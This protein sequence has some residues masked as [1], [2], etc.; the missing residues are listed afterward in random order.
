L[1]KH[2]KPNDYVVFSCGEIDCRWHIPNHKAEFFEDPIQA[3]KVVVYRYLSL[4]EKWKDYRPIPLLCPPH[5][6]CEEY[7]QVLLSARADSW[8]V[9][10]DAIDERHFNARDNFLKLAAN[11]SIP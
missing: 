6:W 5:P 2:W 4:L 9:V 1:E 3:T 10:G 7:N 8:P 11:I